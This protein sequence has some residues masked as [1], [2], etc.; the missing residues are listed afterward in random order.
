MLYA[1]QLP[2]KEREELKR[3]VRQEVGRIS[4]RAQ[5]ILLSARRKTVPE[6]ADLFQ[7][8]QATIRFWVERFNAQ[9]PGGLYDEERSG[10]PPKTTLEVRD[11]VVEL[12]QDDP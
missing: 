12:V 2:D 3:M 5:V 6:I 11:T 7:V 10:R 8:S 9:G 4:Q 1:R